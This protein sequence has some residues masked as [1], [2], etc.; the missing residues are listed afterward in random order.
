M[1]ADVRSDPASDLSLVLGGPFHAL[2]G[3]LGLTGPAGLPTRRVSLGLALFAW[4][5]PASLAIAQTLLDPG[6]SGWGYFSDWTA[7]ARYLIAIP[8][9]VW[10]ERYADGRL[11]LLAEHFRQACLLSD[12]DQP[13][14]ESAFVHAD[15]RSG[16]TVAELAVLVIALVWASVTAHY[17]TELAGTSWE[18]TNIG[19]ENL[20][21]WAGQAARLV[22]TP[23]FLFLLLRWFWRFG[24]W[25]GLLYR[26]ARLP[27]QLTPFHPDRSA[28]LGFLAIYPSIFSGLVFALS[29]VVAA[30]MVKE[31]GLDPT[32]AELVWSAI[33]GWITLCTLLFLGPLLVFA[34]PLYR[35]RERALIDYGRLA[36]Q[37]HLAFHRKW[38]ASGNNGAD[39]LGSTEPSS[40]A[41]LNASIEAVQRM[42][43]VPVDLPAVLQLLIAAGTPMLAVVATQVP[44]GQ[45]V[46]WV[47]GN[48]V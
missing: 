8:I 47:V 29:C 23:L 20:L 43:F 42:R 26:I 41:D 2:L 22:S 34:R 5:L 12:R 14:F 32:P 45:L 16:S 48:I 38:V 15:R 25:T 4:L 24:V 13:A 30:A 7:H 21:S 3:R 17:S 19:G 35:V 31:I 11:I 37:H 6:Y 46:R 1:H 44:F 27:L 28:G 36:S 9:L 33:G 18:G 39:L 40:T 10:T